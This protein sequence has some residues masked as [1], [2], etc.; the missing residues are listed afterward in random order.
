[1]LLILSGVYDRAGVQREAEPVGR[2]CGHATKLIGNRLS[3]YLISG[4]ESAAV[5]VDRRIAALIGLRGE[6]RGAP[7]DGRPWSGRYGKA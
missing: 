6:A 3:D 5:L 1:M 4:Q 2:S 7:T